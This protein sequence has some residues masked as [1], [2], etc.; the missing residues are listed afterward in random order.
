MNANEYGTF[1][2]V[3]G[4]K[5]NYQDV[6]ARDALISQELAKKNNLKVGSNSFH[7]M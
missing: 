5:L 3:E 7:V 6:T 2:V 4:N 1:K